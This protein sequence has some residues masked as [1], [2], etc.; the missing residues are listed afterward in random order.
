MEMFL[1]ESLAGSLPALLAGLVIKPA[2]I[3]GCANEKL[4]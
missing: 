1:F 3:R 2:N 4:V